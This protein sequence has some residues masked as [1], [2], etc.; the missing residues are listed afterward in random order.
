VARAANFTTSSV[1]PKRIF[2]ASLIYQLSTTK[3]VGR[4]AA[5]H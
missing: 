5:L 1:W 3:E 2:R 4:A